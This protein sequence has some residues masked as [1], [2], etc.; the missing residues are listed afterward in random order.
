MDK[1]EK[2]PRH[3]LSQVWRQQFITLS[4]YLNWQRAKDTQI[5]RECGRAVLRTLKYCQD[6]KSLSHDATESPS[7]E[8]SDRTNVISHCRYDLLLSCASVALPFVGILPSSLVTKNLPFFNS[9]QQV[10]QMM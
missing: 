1:Q 3:I 7:L 8:T 2:T 10:L 4:L 5:Q 6:S 9:F